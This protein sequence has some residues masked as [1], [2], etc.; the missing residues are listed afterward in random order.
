MNKLY[1]CYICG[2]KYSYNGKE[3]C[4]KKCE[5]EWEN[6]LKKIFD[7]G[8]LK[9]HHA[10]QKIRIDG[11]WLDDK[12]EFSDYICMINTAETGIN[13]DEDMTIF[14]YFDSWKDVLSFCQ[15]E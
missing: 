9:N 6:L 1:R 8:V 15:K 14:Y 2:K 5:K 3:T 10:K 13:E 12:S 4:S 11:F 7:D